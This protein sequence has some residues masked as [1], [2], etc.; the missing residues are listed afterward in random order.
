[1][2]KGVE[3]GRYV[4]GDLIEPKTFRKYK[5]SSDGSIVSEEYTVHGRKIPLKKI[6]ET[7]FSDHLKEGLWNNAS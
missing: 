1:M 3:S 5:L 4:L 7:L 2:L 6:R